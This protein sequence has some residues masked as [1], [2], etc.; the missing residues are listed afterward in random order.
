MMSFLRLRDSRDFSHYSSFAEWADKDKTS[1]SALSEADVEGP[2]VA[3]SARFSCLKK[4]D[5]EERPA[6]TGSAD[7]LINLDTFLYVMSHFATFGWIWVTFLQS[8]Q[9]FF[10]TT[11]TFSKSFVVQATHRFFLLVSL[12]CFL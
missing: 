10:D 12:F 9:N 6:V 4:E 3:G 5:I 1:S 11:E 7:F 2:A 8:F